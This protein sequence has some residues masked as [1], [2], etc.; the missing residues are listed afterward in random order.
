[1][2]QRYSSLLPGRAKLVIT[3]AAA[4]LIADDALSSGLG[5]RALDQEVSALVARANLLCLR[6]QLINQIVIDCPQ[7]SDSLTLDICTSANGL[8]SMRCIKE[9]HDRGS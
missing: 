3:S 8:R 5:A 4:S 1:M 6:N 9:A 7:G 2:Q